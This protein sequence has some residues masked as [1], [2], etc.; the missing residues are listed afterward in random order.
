MK[1]RVH[2]RYDL[3]F[4]QQFD[5]RFGTCVG[6]PTQGNA[7]PVRNRFHYASDYHFVPGSF[8]PSH[9]VPIS[10]LSLLITW[11]KYYDMISD[12]K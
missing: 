2:L 10:S 7:L 1:G 4:D 11:T 12:L 5:Q 8:V 6:T 3:R 9:S